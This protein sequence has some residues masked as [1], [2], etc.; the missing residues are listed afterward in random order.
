[1]WTKEEKPKNQMFFINDGQEGTNS[2]VW[3]KAKTWFV[4]EISPT[5]GCVQWALQTIQQCKEYR[6][7]GYSACSQ[8]ADEG[9]SGGC[10][11]WADEGSS[12]GCSQ[13]ADEGSYH[14]CTWWPCSWAC[15]AFYW[16]AKWVCKAY[17]WIAKLVCKA[18]YWIA[19]LVCKAWYWISSL[20]CIAWA[21]FVKWV[22]VA[23]TSVT[24][25]I[26]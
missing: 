22:C 26:M 14:C 6:D 11:Q 3:I 16:V 15:K 5:S 7:N 9:S 12:G 17:Y 21:T 4:G 10:S 24:N 20:I 25:I 1:M 19:K 23:F 2:D 13:W 8:W 18:Y